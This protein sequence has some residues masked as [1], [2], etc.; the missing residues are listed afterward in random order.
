M[1]QR[2]N[3]LIKRDWAIYSTCYEDKE[4][5]LLKTT[6]PKQQQQLRR[7]N[8]IDGWAYTCTLH[9]PHYVNKGHISSLAP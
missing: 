5:K 2:I 9:K 8:G 4:L 1:G 7:C 6:Q 3:Y